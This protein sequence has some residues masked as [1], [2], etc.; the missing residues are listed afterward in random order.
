MIA[1][2]YKTLA[3]ASAVAEKFNKKMPG[4][5]SKHFEYEVKKRYLA[6]GMAENTPEEYE[7]NLVPKDPFLMANRNL[8]KAYFSVLLREYYSPVGLK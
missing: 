7:V 2:T 8:H 5:F 6:V 4:K 1:N 3:E